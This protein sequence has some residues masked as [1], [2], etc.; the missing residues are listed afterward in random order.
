MK[1]S[2]CLTVAALV[3]LA[4]RLYASPAQP[5]RA[6]IQGTVVQVQKYKVYSPDFP[7]GGNNPSD[8]PLTSR[9]YAYVVSIRIDCKTY[10]G[11]YETPFNYLPSLFTPDQPIQLRL[12]KHVMYFNLPDH[13]DLRMAIVHRRSQC[14]QNRE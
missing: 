12:T 11:R 6:Y 7:M 9:Y 2:L 8:A 10:V 14:G 3:V 13:E 4:P 5:S 1:T